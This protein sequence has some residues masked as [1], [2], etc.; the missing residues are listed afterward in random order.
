MIPAMDSPIRS[1]ITHRGPVFDVETIH[2]RDGDREIRRDI[3][4]HPG[5]VAIVAELADG[6]LALVRNYRISVDQRLLELPAGK[7]EPDESPRDAAARE[8]VEETG[9]RAR[10]IEPL[11]EFFTSPGFADERMYVFVARGLEQFGQRLEPGESIQVEL[12]AAEDALAMSR[13]GRIIDGK[14]IA[15]LALWRGFAGVPSASG[16][17]SDTGIAP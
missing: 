7:L 9:F 17:G 5:A 12:V 4:R 10:S 14:T 6:R 16:V 13:D 2:L 1:E 3:V 15:G 11:G 8:L